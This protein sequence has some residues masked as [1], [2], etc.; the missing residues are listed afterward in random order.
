MSKRIHDT[1]RSFKAAVGPHGDGRV[2]CCRNTSALDEERNS[3]QLPSQRFAIAYLPVRIGPRR[4]GIET[5]SIEVARAR[6]ALSG[7]SVLR[8]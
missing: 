1:A 8:G 5:R 4:N 3:V 2:K 6:E 7:E